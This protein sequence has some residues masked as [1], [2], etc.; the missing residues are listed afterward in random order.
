MTLQERTDKALAAHAIAVNKYAFSQRKVILSELNFILKEIKDALLSGNRDVS[1]ANIK[2][3]ANKAEK[4][5]KDKFKIIRN[6]INSDLEEFIE[7][8]SEG[9][10]KLMETLMDK[11]SPGYT[12]K[13]PTDKM[14]KS[15]LENATIRNMLISS[16]LDKWELDLTSRIKGALYSDIGLVDDRYELVNGVFGED[17]NVLATPTFARP[18]VDLNALLLSFTDAAAGVVSEGLVDYNTGVIKGRM[19]NSCLCATTCLTCAS[20]HG[21][22]HYT[23]GEDETNGASI[24]A[25]INCL[26]YWT[27]IYED[28]RLMN[29]RIPKNK[30]SDINS[31]ERPL[32]FEEYLESLT[33]KEKIELFGPKRLKLLEDG[34]IT[35]NKMLDINNGKRV[36]TLE[37]LR[38]Q[39]Y[40]I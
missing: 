4:M 40:E 11:Y 5:F 20:L 12:Y 34:K 9:Q 8:E 24:P 22:I 38:L 2:S 33:E 7:T 3:L 29:A 21:A 32:T 28:A 27:Y 16:S 30:Q 25:H 39:G 23:D 18:G 1:T 37:E 13:M 35:V 31:S 6:N 26:C 15:D 36:F 17:D 19:W 10:V 14:L